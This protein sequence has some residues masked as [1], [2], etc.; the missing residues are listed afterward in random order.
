[1]SL[2]AAGVLGVVVGYGLALLREFFRIR[3]CEEDCAVLRQMRR[4][5]HDQDRVVGALYHQTEKLARLL[6]LQAKVDATR[7]GVAPKV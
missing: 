3:E 7:N 4:E 6:V 1:M 5:Q 2:V